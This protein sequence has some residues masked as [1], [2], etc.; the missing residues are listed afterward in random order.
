MKIRTEQISPLQQQDRERVRER[1]ETGK[2]GELLAQEV[3][4]TSPQPTD[5][6]SAALAGARA[7]GATQLLAT[8]S[9]ATTDTQSATEQ[10][11]MENIDSLLSKWENYA[12]Q[13]STPL[14]EESLRQAYGMLETI[15]DGVQRLKSD[16]PNLGQSNPSL[17]S[18]VDEIE[19]LTVTEQFKFNRGDY[20]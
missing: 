8:Q 6:A 18:M 4:K 16:A 19:I 5:Q 9:A 15:Q 17:Q 1:E 20:L 7:L 14:A 10:K 3:H 12:Q 11:V 2:F 13:L